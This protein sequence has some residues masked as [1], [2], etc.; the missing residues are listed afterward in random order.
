MIIWNDSER[1]PIYL[2]SGGITGCISA[3][4]ET[5]TVQ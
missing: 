5:I 2:S 1:F 4:A 3:R